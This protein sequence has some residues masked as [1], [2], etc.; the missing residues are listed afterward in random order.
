MF[1][2]IGLA[3]LAGV[4]ALLL[5]PMLL[6]LVRSLVDLV[7]HPLKASQ[8]SRVTI[9]V[10]DLCSRR[11]QITRSAEFCQAVAQLAQ[12]LRGE[13]EEAGYPLKNTEVLEAILIGIQESE[14]VSPRYLLEIERRISASFA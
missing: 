2:A 12:Q 5:I 14:T 8:L 4:A 7:R 9:A 11:P 3:A 10:K 13:A 6:R 1:L